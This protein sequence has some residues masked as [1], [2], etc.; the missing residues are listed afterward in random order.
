MEY[1][2][3]EINPPVSDTGDRC[4]EGI[5]PAAHASSSGEGLPTVLRASTVG[6]YAIA[7][8]SA[9]PGDTHGLESCKIQK[10]AE[11]LETEF[12]QAPIV[13]NK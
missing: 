6:E 11:G 4:F 10:K 7:S 5:V 3:T 1:E 2:I 9:Y 12:K 13:M 8:D